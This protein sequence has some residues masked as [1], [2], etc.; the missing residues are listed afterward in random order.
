MIF[1]PLVGLHENVVVLDYDS[2]Y[3]NLIL[4]YNISYETVVYPGN[5]AQHTGKR[6]L[7][8]VIEKVVS[9]RLYFKNIRQKFDINSL[10]WTWCEQRIAVLKTI[11]VCLYGTTVSLW[12]RFAKILAFEEI[13]KIS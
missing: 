12:N 10:E 1:S 7:S 5:V 2:E 11:L 4:K 9:R 3:A 13:N 6:L 8:T